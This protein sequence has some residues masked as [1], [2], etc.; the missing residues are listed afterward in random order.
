[1]FL[2]QHQTRLQTECD[3]GEKKTLSSKSALKCVWSVYSLSPPLSSLYHHKTH[4]ITT[5]ETTV[6]YRSYSL[7]SFSLAACFLSEGP[8]FEAMF[9]Y[10]FFFSLTSPYCVISVSIYKLIGITPHLY[11]WYQEEKE[12]ENNIW[13]G[14]DGLVSLPSSKPFSEEM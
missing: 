13:A 4:V 5:R 6:I 2:P 3:C 1:M 11:L 12:H 14:Y 10:F 9:L 8:S 7:S